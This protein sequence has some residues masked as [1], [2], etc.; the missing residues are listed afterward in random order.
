MKKRQ[1][2]PEHFFTKEEEK[3]IVSAVKE[4]ES[5]TSGEIRVHLEAHTDEPNREHAEKIFTEMGMA[6]TERRNGVLFYMALQDH[7][8]SIVGDQGLN[9]K[10][11]EGFWDEIRDGMQDQFRRGNFVEGLTDGV[12][13]AGKAL[14]DYFPKGD[15]NPNELTDEISKS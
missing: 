12:K 4:A 14:K 1:E 5:H 3:Q 9:E 8:F 11:P 15:D 10:V 6:E 13:S 7:Q 2:K